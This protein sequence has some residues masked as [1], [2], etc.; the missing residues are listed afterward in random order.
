MDFVDQQTKGARRYWTIRRPERAN[1][2]G[3]SVAHELAS[4]LAELKVELSRTDSGSAITALIIG[5]EPVQKGGGPRTWI[6]GGDLKELAQLQT[7]AEAASYAGTMAGVVAGLYTLPLPVVIAIDGAAIGGGAELALAGDLRLGTKDSSL[8]FRQLKIGLI[9]GYGTCQHLVRLVGLAQA[10]RLLYGATSLSAE[11]ARGMGLIHNVYEDSAQLAA[12][13][14]QVCTQ[15]ASY[16]LAAFAA[17][18]RLLGLGAAD[19]ALRQRELE[20]FQGLWRNPVHDH[21]LRQFAGK[22]P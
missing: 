17:Q 19:P 16:G 12:G 11:A 21:C 2:L 4:A 13:V 9:T 22:R 6:G 18:K 14:E 7:A 20:E 10:Q 15:L 1:G 3:I 5:A 8:D